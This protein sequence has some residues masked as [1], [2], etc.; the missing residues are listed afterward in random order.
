MRGILRAVEKSKIPAFIQIAPTNIPVSG[1][2]F[3][4]D[5]VTRCAKDMDT[6]IALHLDHGKTFDS[7]RQAARAGFTSVMTDNAKYAYDENIKHTYE[8]VQ[9]AKGYGI[10]VEAELGA[11]AGKEDDDVTE[12]HN[13]TNPDQVVDF[14]TRTGVNLLAVAVGNVHGLNLDPNIDFPL[15][16]K[17]KAICP[18]PL[19]LHGASGIPDDQIAQMVDN[20]VIKINVASDLRRAFIESAGKD[21][22]ADPERFDLVNV[23][24]DAEKAIE[25]VVYHKIQ[26]MNSKSPTPVR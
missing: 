8:A 12:G 5:M 19:V 17:I 11:I 25:D 4:A 1:Y 13:K 24:L 20:G 3:I 14:V 6:P 16:K 18:V 26:V 22:Q 9:F 10:P 7:V 2:G 15:L 21:Y 23:S